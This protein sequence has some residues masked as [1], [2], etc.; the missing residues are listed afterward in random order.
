M[1]RVSA[2]DSNKCQIE[3]PANR[4]SDRLSVVLNFY[5]ISPLLRGAAGE[6]R[7]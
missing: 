6:S 3:G 2:R 7:A 1:H 4:R 5:R